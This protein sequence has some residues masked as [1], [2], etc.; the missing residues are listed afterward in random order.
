MADIPQFKVP[1]RLVGEDFAVVEQD[2]EQEIE[3]GVEAVVRYRKGARLTLPKFGITDPAF[4]SEGPSATIAGD[5]AAS[6]L[7][8]EPRATVL[9][10][11]SSASIVDAIMGV[12]LRLR[13]TEGAGS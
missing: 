9:I 2:T 4:V 13:L 3:Q 12:V 1:I 7:E 6:V 8:W 11:Q 10:E 5:I